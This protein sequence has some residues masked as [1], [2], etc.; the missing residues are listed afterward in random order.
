MSEQAYL[1]QQEYSP[2]RA[3]SPVQRGVI[4]MA[5]GQNAIEQAN[6]SIES[7]REVEPS[8]PVMVVGDLLSE[9]HYKDRADVQFRRIDIDPFFGPQFMAGRIK[10]LLYAL[11]PWEQTLYV[12]ADTEFLVAPTV[13]FELLEKWDFVVAETETRSLLDSISGPIETRW[14]ADW[15]GTPHLLFHNSGML[16]WRKSEAV[17]RLF[18]LWGEE[19]LRF[20]GWDEQ[21]ALLRALLRSDVLYLTVP[22]TWNCLRET[23]A[24]L[25]HHHF[26]TRM[27]RK[28]DDR[29]ALRRQWR[30]IHAANPM[31]VPA[32]RPVAQ[33]HVQQHAAALVTAEVAPGRFVRCRPNEVEA[34][35]RRWAERTR[36]RR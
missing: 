11:S 7:L 26:G 18:E 3:C 12:D 31:A 34:V 28:Y 8:M 27:A 32:L 13:G 20:Q 29:P 35:K 10:P 14:T 25:L 6:V 4:Y 2:Q 1:P 36:R 9:L 16:F 23:E 19:W 15:L 17:A 24:T 22:F 30:R 5:W 21:V 33:R